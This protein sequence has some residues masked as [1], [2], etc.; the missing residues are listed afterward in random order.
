MLASLGRLALLSVSRKAA[1]T[2]YRGLSAVERRQDTLLDR[3]ISDL[4]GTEYGRTFNITPG[5][6]Y[7]KFCKKLPIVTYNDLE[8]YIQQSEAGEPDVLTQQPIRF[9]EYTSGSSSAVKHIPYTPGLLQSFSTMFKIWAYDTLTHVYRPQTGKAFML[10]SPGLEGTGDDRRFLS[11]PL[12]AILSPYLIIPKFTATSTP[13]NAIAS[14]LLSARDLEVISVWSPSLLCNLMDHMEITS[15]AKTS[16]AWPKL[17]FIS[18]WTSGPSALFAEKLHT[19]FPDVTIQGKGLLATEAPITIPIHSANGFVP[20]IDE[21]FLEFED[22]GGTMFRLHELSKDETY[23]II[24]SQKG[25]LYRCRIGDLVHVNGFYQSA[26]LLNFVGREGNVSDLV[27]EKLDEAFVIRVLEPLIKDY[28]VCVPSLSNSVGQYSVLVS[29]HP[30]VSVDEA[31][32]SSYHY[33]RARELGQLNRACVHQIPFLPQLVQDY[34]LSNGMRAGDF[35]PPRLI[36]DLDE[37]K[38]FWQFVEHATSHTT[39][40][41]AE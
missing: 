29:R 21:V 10:I 32:C 36:A 15:S 33:L 8:P 13:L 4:S 1:Q 24:L 35:K 40:H 27:G 9:F 16:V 19:L 18:C 23:S 39:A 20:L 34:Y 17:K 37:A 28:F 2:F 38:D 30:Y 26:P 11:G 25:G 6:S 7:R 14:C 31:L 12:Q 41:Q 3:L 22:H 5:D